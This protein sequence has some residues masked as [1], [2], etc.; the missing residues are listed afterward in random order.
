VCRLEEGLL[1]H[2]LHAAGERS[3]VRAL[4]GAA[5]MAP[6]SAPEAQCVDQLDI[7]GVYFPISPRFVI[8][9]KLSAG[10]NFIGLLPRG[11]AAVK[12]SMSS[13]DSNHTAQRPQQKRSLSTS[14]SDNFPA[15]INLLRGVWAKSDRSRD[16]KTCDVLILFPLAHFLSYPT[17]PFLQI[18]T[19]QTSF[20]RS[21]WAHW[22]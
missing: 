13:H 12:F 21:N 10:L 3:D 4:L 8:P 16:L 5:L 9:S 20:E 11:S 18:Y 19:T 7:R 1:R 2:A 17:Y 15:C 14:F 22:F 6:V